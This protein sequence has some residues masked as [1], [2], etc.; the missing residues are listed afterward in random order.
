MPGPLQGKFREAWSIGNRCL[1]S[2]GQLGTSWCRLTSPF[3]LTQPQ[4]KDKRPA[5]IYGAVSQQC[6]KHILQVL[7][8]GGLHVLPDSVREMYTS[9]GLL[10]PAEY[11]G[12][13][14]SPPELVRVP[15]LHSSTH[16]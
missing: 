4:P 16:A 8:W 11:A 14:Q 6:T 1:H 10:L 7:L 3:P 5:W 13:L 2:P 15:Q 9:P 12:G